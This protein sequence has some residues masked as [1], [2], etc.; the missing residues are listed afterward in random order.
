MLG[1]ETG[2]KIKDSVRVTGEVYNRQ[3]QAADYIAYFDDTV[4]RV[5]QISAAIPVADRPSVLYIDLRPLRRPNRIME[6]MLGRVGAESVT[7]DVSIGQFQFG[8]E[9]LQ[10]WN[11][12]MLIGMEPYDLTGL[13][14][15]PKY[16]ALRAVRQKK[17]GIIPTGVQ[18]WGNNTTEQ[19]L[20][21]LWVATYLH[22]RQYASI[23]MP[24]ETKNFY[25]RFYGVA[26][27]DDQITQLLNAAL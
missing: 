24:T 8:V 12:Q 10:Q 11:P 13:T 5:D 18:I 27:T 16:A 26:L 3:R 15:D 1:L 25:Q 19:P 9:Q 17:I 20:G 7:R 21:L 14:T 2:D 23:D 6:W 22:P 4:E